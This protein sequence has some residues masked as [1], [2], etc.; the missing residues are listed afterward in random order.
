MID[1]IYDDKRKIKALHFD[2]S[3]FSIYNGDNGVRKIIP[4]RE[5]GE[6]AYITFYAVYKNQVTTQE[7]FW[8]QRIPASTCRIEYEE[9]IPNPPGGET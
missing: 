6:M 8:W 2:M 9:P 4:Y 5:Y 7:E 3:Q 1:L